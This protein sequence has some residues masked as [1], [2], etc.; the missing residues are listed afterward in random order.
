MTGKPRNLLVVMSDEHR[1]DALG[2]MGHP[3]VRTPAL[4]RLATRGSLFTNAY[5][6]SPICVPARAALATGRHIHD[7]GHWD[8]AAPYAGSPRS[9]MH[10]LRDRGVETVSFGKLHFRSSGDDNG[11]SREILPMHVAGGI[12]WTVGLLRDEPPPFEAAAELAADVGP[13]E[14]SYTRYDRAVADEAER[15]LR[16]RIRGREPWAAFVSFVAPHYPFRAPGPFLRLYSPEAVDRPVAEGERP[17]HPELARLAAFW[18]YGR[19]FDARR[20]R[21]ARAAYYGLVSFMDDC[22]GRV[23]AALAASG[24]DEDT[25]VLYLS[26]HGEMLGDH[27]FWTKSVMYEAS[28]GVPLIAAGPGVPSGRRVAT[29]ASLLDVAATAARLCGADDFAAGLPGAS[30]L[31]LAQAPDDPE[32]TAFSE[33]HDGGSSTGAF[34][35]RW[36]RWKYVHYAGLAPQLFDLSADPGERLDLAESTRGRHPALRE[37]ARR[38]QRICDPEAVS[39]RAFADQRRRIGVFGG[40]LACRANAFNHTPAPDV[41]AAEVQATDRQGEATC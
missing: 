15:W 36:D 4:D 10:A 41:A 5:T 26:D 7:T 40:P 8:S 13:G 38:L 33:Y 14:S 16:G 27:G 30:L 1:R 9:W 3:L 12:G 17:S 32:R 20:A 31:D 19:H 35:L 29:A 22:V 39:A 21:E 25:L 28:A 34:L 23:L 11:F 6:P 2:C 18:D 37:G 24:A